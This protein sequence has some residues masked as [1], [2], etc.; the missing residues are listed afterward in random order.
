L[1]RLQ[2]V[3]YAAAEE[4]EA[5]H[6]EGERLALAADLLEFGGYLCFSFAR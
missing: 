6:G 4:A 2:L 1:W 5:R 3:G